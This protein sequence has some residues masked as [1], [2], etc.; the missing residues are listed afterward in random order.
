MEG[1]GGIFC[2]FVVFVCLCLAVLMKRRRESAA[3]GVIVLGQRKDGRGAGR[4]FLRE[5]LTRH[6]ASRNG[7]KRL[8]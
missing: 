4:P 7:L 8:A 6:S 2:V 1:V 3:R 5:G